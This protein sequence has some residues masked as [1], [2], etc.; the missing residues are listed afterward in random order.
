MSDLNNAL[1]EVLQGTTQSAI[2]LPSINETEW[3]WEVLM[4]Q[5]KMN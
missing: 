4:R 5:T 1:Q 3:E 2:N